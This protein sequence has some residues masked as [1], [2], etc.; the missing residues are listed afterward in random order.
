M[1][2]WVIICRSCVLLFPC[3]CV[4]VSFTPS[5]GFH[6]DLGRVWK[7]QM[8]PQWGLK[9]RRWGWSLSKRCCIFFSLLSWLMWI[10]E[11][12]GLEGD[13]DTVRVQQWYAF[14][15]Q[16]LTPFSSSL[17]RR[18]IWN[19]THGLFHP[20]GPSSQQLRLQL[21]TSGTPWSPSSCTCSLPSQRNASWQYVFFLF[22]WLCGF[23]SCICFAVVPKSHGHVKNSQPH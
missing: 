11:G 18:W 21:W 1:S 17:H 22:V 15:A 20:A 3:V 4:F 10:F 2:S 6:A 5:Q 14:S 23:L 9:E 19:T 8:K 16:K 7:V 13:P 12:L